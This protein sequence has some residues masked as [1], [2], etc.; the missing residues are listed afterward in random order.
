MKNQITA[1]LILAVIS[2]VNPCYAQSTNGKDTGEELTETSNLEYLKKIKKID[3]HTHVRSGQQYLIDFMD[4]YNF[5]Y[6]A[7]VNIGGPKHNS[8]EAQTDTAK[9]LYNNY[10]RYYSW[11][12]TFDV[13]KRHQPGWA[14][15]VINQLKDDF[16]NGAVGVKMWKNVGMDFKEPNGEYLQ[17]DNPIFEPIFEFIASQNK[18]VFAHI[19]DPIEGWLPFFEKGNITGLKYRI[20]ERSKFSFWEKADLPTYKEIMAARDN[21]LQ[22]HSNLKFVGAHLGSLEFDVDEI[23]IRLE[24]FPNFAVELGGRTSYLMQQANGK[25]RDFFIRYQDRIMYGTDRGAKP[26][27]T[28]NDIKKTKEEILHRNEIF[29][30]YFATDDEIPWGNIILGDTPKPEPSYSV[31]GINLP[32]DILDKVFYKNAV[33]WFP[34]VDKDF[35]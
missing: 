18:A 11:M 31:R 7:I 3:I 14:N 13:S 29:L 33:K 19:G 8:K 26:T 17:I 35:K 27:M 10:P 12:T 25:V 30:K 1:L 20:E 22:K 21:V 6:C 15:M 32:K 34:E 5:K 4:E 28:L 9:M 2:F 16:D 23:S 24:Q